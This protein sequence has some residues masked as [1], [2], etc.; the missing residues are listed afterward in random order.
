MLHLRNMQELDP[1]VHVGQAGAFH[2]SDQIPTFFEG[3]AGR[4]FAEHMLARFK[5]GNGLAGVERDRRRYADGIHV[6][7]V[8]ELFEIRGQANAGLNA[9]CSF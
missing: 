5:R 6:R 3:V 2:R 8:Q 7:I 1:S 4:E 9:F